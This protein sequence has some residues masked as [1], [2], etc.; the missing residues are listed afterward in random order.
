M[1]VFNS[2]VLWSSYCGSLKVQDVTEYILFAMKTLWTGSC[3]LVFMWRVSK[4]GKG[5]GL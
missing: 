4:S 2:V 3:G 5:L 1:P